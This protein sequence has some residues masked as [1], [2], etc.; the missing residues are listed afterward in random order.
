MVN[1]LHASAATAICQPI[2]ALARRLLRVYAFPSCSYLNSFDGGNNQNELNPGR[3]KR[4]VPVMKDSAVLLSLF[5]D[6]MHCGGVHVHQ[7]RI[8]KGTIR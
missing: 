2:L 1:R 7:P 4:L 3:N 5:V 8:Q 6:V